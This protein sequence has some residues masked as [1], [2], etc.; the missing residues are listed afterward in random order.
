MTAADVRSAIEHIVYGYAERVDAGDF[1][2]LADLF[3]DATY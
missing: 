3:R 2:G 1:A